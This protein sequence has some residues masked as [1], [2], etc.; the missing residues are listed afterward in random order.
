MITED[1]IEFPETPITEKTFEKQGWLRVDETE[2]GFDEEED[3]DDDDESN[4]DSIT[5]YYYI[6]PLPKDNPDS[7]CK[8][9]I[10]NCNDE[11]KDIGLP[12]G[13]YYVEL[14]NA[15]GLGLCQSEEQIEILYRSLTGRDIYE[16]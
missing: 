2:G 8:L 12:K 15:N 9:L 1:H 6:L 10:S 11:Y 5:Y 16:D 7:E 14:E 4:S 3:D 13:Q